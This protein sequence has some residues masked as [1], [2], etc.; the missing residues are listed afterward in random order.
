MW[1]STASTASTFPVPDDEYRNI[2]SKTYFECVLKPFKFQSSI[3]DEKWCLQ[4]IENI[5]CNCE[6]KLEAKLK[7]NSIQC[8]QDKLQNISETINICPTLRKQY[9]DSKIT[10]INNWQEFPCFSVKDY[11]LGYCSFPTIAIELAGHIH[12]CSEDILKLLGK[13]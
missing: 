12:I 7:S 1:S 4:L 6:N 2:N 3:I 11:I 5:F 9:E 13:F 10:T 8:D